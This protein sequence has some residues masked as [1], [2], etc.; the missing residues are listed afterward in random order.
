VKVKRGKEKMAA[1]ALVN[2]AADFAAQSK[3]LEILS[4]TYTENV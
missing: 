2:K 4:A 1:I 3:P